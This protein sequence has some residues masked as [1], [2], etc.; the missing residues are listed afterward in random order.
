MLGLLALT[1][2]NARLQHSAR[3]LRLF[4]LLLAGAALVPCFLLLWPTPRLVADAPIIW[5]AQGGYDTPAP[6]PVYWPTGQQVFVQ[7]HG[8]NYRLEG[9]SPAF[10]FRRHA[11]ITLQGRDL[12]ITPLHGT[13]RRIA[14][15]P[16]IPNTQAVVSMQPTR[17]GVLLN[18]AVPPDQHRVVRVNFTTNAVQPVPH[19]WRVR[20]AEQT[21]RYVVRWSQ[22]THQVRDGHDRLLRQHGMYPWRF[23]EWDADP[24]DDL[25]AITS[26]INVT[27]IGPDSL[28]M[29]TIDPDMRL[30]SVTMQPGLHQLWIA[31]ETYGR[32][33][34]MPP[35]RL[36]I[37]AYNGRFLGERTIAGAQVLRALPV[38]PAM[39]EYLV[40]AYGAHADKARRAEIR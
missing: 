39:A 20:G 38:E 28:T 4:G 27:L 1:A 36:R 29:S 32:D 17:D 21:D 10:A 14:L 30:A 16:Q 34:P 3:P 35:C 2:L 15:K 19:A 40:R 24:V 7:W 31:E 33:D 18:L 37:Y 23:V 11:L 25:F 6:T 8:N 13:P 26:R 22:G 12:V 5:V 9:L